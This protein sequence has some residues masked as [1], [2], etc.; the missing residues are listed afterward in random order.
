[1]ANKINLIAFLHKWEGGF[2]NHPNDPGGAT[3][4][5]ITLNTFREYRKRLGLPVPSVTDLKDIGDEEWMDI[6]S[7]YYW[8]PWGA[9][10]I[11]SQAIANMVVDFGWMSGTVNAAKRIQNIPGSGL[12]VDGIIG[13][14]S[15][16]FINFQNNI[17]LFDTIWLLRCNHFI[18]ICIG[19]E[20][21]KVFLKGWLNRLY[22]HVPYS[23][24][25]TTTDGTSL[26]P[27]VSKLNNAHLR[28]IQ[29]IIGAVTDGKFGPETQGKLIEYSKPL[30]V[31]DFSWLKLKNQY[32]DDYLSNRILGSELKLRMKTLFESV[33]SI[34]RKEK[35]K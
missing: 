27:V 21:S 18:D 31:F 1:M 30:V 14:K 23:F 25:R 35:F 16:Q 19:R 28:D 34:T 29:K 26:I 22:D 6:Y 20:A 15:L 13:N 32:V 33:Q 12:T 8:N 2:V 10:F 5:G 11:N 9:D 4:I 24:E 7:R 17:S 3:N